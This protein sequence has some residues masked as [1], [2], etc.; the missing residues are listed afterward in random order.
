M[1]RECGHRGGRERRGRRGRRERRGPSARVV[2]GLGVGLGF[3]LVTAFSAAPAPATKA[4]PTS[5]AAATSP[6]KA[7]RKATATRRASE[8]VARP[9]RTAPAS[10]VGASGRT[11]PRRAAARPLTL[12]AQKIVG[13][14][15]APRVLFVHAEPSLAL[16][17]APVRPSYFRDDFT[18][19]LSSPVRVRP[20]G[21]EPL[22]VDPGMGGAP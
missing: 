12:D 20:H 14:V 6:A 22:R 7:G 1:T 8:P 5:K 19:A 11:V 2:L 4:A 9:S 17:A 10:A 13:R 21:F 15:T 16:E 18:A 3:M